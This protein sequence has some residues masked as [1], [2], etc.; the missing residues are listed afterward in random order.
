MSIFVA[1]EGKNISQ[2]NGE[3]V[4]SLNTK[5][6]EHLPSTRSVKILRMSSTIIIKCNYHKHCKRVIFHILADNIKTNQ[7]S[8]V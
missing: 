6:P 8:Y 5:H 2:N 3:I 1:C 4:R 7:D